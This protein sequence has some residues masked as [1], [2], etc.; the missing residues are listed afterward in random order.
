[1]RL[2]GRFY[3]EYTKFRS[4]ISQC[5]K[6]FRFF[7]ISN[8]VKKPNIPKIKICLWIFGKIT[9]NIE[10]FHDLSEEKSPASCRLVSLQNIWKMWMTIKS[11]KTAMKIPFSFRHSI[12]NIK[13]HVVWTAYF[14][15][16]KRAICIYC[17]EIIQKK[18]I[19]W[20]NFLINDLK[21]IDCKADLLCR[22]Y[23]CAVQI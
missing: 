13:F 15:I 2:I 12:F 22:R 3:F 16:R 1:M 4:I 19:N 18:Y 9:R 5:W 14:R 23:S 20:Y 7:E 17:T 6:K 8:N 11:S 10:Y 21:V